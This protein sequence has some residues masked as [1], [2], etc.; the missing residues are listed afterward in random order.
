MMSMHRSYSE[1]VHSTFS[2]GSPPITPPPTGASG[3]SF[4]AEKRIVS[5]NGSLRLI[6]VIE[7]RF[8]INREESD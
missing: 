2:N 7:P 4:F 8:N 5:G 3:G 1:Q 6:D